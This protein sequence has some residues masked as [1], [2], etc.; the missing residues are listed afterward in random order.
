MKRSASQ[1]HLVPHLL[2]RLLQRRETVAYPYGPLELQ[3]TY[4]GRVVVDI[5]ACIGCG[6][7]VRV[8]PTGGLK[9]ERLADRGVRVRIE[10]QRCASCGLC[11]VSCRRDAIRLV[12]AFVDPA[13]SKDEL[14]E[15]WVRQRDHDR[16]QREQA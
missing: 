16:K 2:R 13:M 10:H 5:D 8:C 14:V 7:C 15:E 3:E 11:E 12:A 9:V 1:S 6:Q 4:Q